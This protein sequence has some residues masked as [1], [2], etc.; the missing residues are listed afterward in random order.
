M[1]EKRLFNNGWEFTRQPP[2]C[3]LEQVC[4]ADCIWTA[5]DIPHDWLISDTSRFYEDGTGW[6]RKRYFHKPLSG[7]RIELRFEGVYMDSTVYVNNAIAG[8][9]SEGNRATVTAHA[10]GRF[11]LRCLSRNGSEDIRLYSR[12]D[13]EISG[14]GTAFL[15][16]YRFISAGLYSAS[17]GDISNGNERGIA[18]PREHEAWIGFDDID[19]GDY[20]SDEITIPLFVLDDGPFSLQIWKGRP[21]RKE[22]ELLADVIYQKKSVWNTYQEQS[23]RLKRRMKGLC[24]LWFVTRRKAH[25]RGFRFTQYRKAREQ[26]AAT[27]F[28]R[29]YGDSY[30]IGSDAVEEIGNNVTLEFSGLDFAEEGTSALVLCGRTDRPINPVHIRFDG[31]AAAQIADFHCS[32]EYSEQKFSLNRICGIHTVS[33]LF[34]PGSCF[35]FR[36][37]RFCSK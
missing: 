20:G 33:F 24:S 32:P 27:G 22:S 10:D 7:T 23:F 34:M 19:F 37:F 35:D 26:L 4:P 16:P 6:Y 28:D 3:T 1:S 5:I 36:W 12:L 14:L 9:E 13:Y 8:V 29:I 11:Q 31:E 18:T 15:D 2:E 17:R 21:D 30:R 25:I